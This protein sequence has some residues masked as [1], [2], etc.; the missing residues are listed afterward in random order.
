MKSDV[1]DGDD[2]RVTQC[3][4]GARLL[5]EPLQLYRIEMAGRTLMATRRPSRTSRA[6]NTTPIPPAPI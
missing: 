2:V 3:G 1:V 4:G 6:E 5:L